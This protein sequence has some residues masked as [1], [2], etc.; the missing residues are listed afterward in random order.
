MTS[1]RALGYWAPTGDSTA[2]A[3]LN[4]ALTQ[5]DK[6]IFAVSRD[7]AI[8]FGIGGHFG[9]GDDAMPV[10]AYV[11]PLPIE[12]LGDPSFCA[13]HGLKYPYC[14]GAMANGIGSEALVEA[15]A[16]AGMLGFFGAA[17]LAPAKIEESLI[18]LGK[19]LDGMSYGF[20]LINTP[21]DQK[22]QEDV[23][24]L[25]IKH[26]LRLVEASAYIG[27]SLPLVK[28]RVSGIYRD[29]DGNVVAPNK[30]IGKLSRM[31]VAT[32]FLS[33]P[34]KKFLKKLLET[35][36]ITEDQATMAGEIPVAQD[37]TAEADSGGHTDHRS[38]LAL[39]S[40]LLGMRDTMQE[41][42][43]YHSRLRIGLAG[44]ISTPASAAAAFAMG[45]AYVLTGS[46]NQSCREAGTSH[47][48]KTTLAK[49]NQTDIEC[50]PSADMFEQGVTVQVLKKG[51]RFA[52]R[53]SKL[54]ELYRSC[55]CIED[56]QPE[57]RAKIEESIF[58]APLEKIWEDTRLFFLQRDPAQV[59]RAEEIPRHKMAL[60]F[61]W[62]LGQSSRWA[63]SG[64]EGREEDFQIWCG[65]A[66]GAFNAWAKNS[67]L[68][69][70]ENRTVKEVALNILFGA[71]V[72]LRASTLRQQGI[73]VPLDM[74]QL[75]P[76]AFS[77]AE[78]IVA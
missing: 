51:T 18:R 41:K 66:M 16:H 76:K 39:L 59:K 47:I 13:D 70:P 50:A 45:A 19:S 61:R 1:N 69:S 10:A 38:A 78:G 48:V 44:G 75:K 22:W 5:I 29:D 74:Q 67:F 58:Q 65:P 3:P 26:G 71:A 34:P 60:I 24:D 73:D 72:V 7:D 17:G 2:I 21:N 37:V 56:I 4:E 36:D 15:M 68:E 11:A 53:A 49:A 55:K 33:P 27:L 40:E 23:A 12:Q 6:P 31:E 25:Y 46:V 57:D 43:Q 52:Q 14:A 54:Y 62:Y 35:G 28:Y 32:R 42:Y 63:N 30:V 64:V 77:Q 9:G 20:N 8:S